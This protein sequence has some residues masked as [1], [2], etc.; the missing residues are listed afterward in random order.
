MLE[1][2]DF[3]CISIYE[4]LD[5]IIFRRDLSY[6]HIQILVSTL[7]LGRRSGLVLFLTCLFEYAEIMVINF[8]CDHTNPT[9]LGDTH[10]ASDKRQDLSKAQ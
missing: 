9:L 5:Y 8:G 10:Q 2:R 7:M 1:R 6:T 3:D 4:K